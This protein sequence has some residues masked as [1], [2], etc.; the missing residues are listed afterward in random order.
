M[1]ALWNALLH[2]LNTIPAW[3]AAAV[4]GWVAS[5]AITQPAKFLM[6]VGWDSELRA[7]VARALA[8]VSAFVATAFAFRALAPDGALAGMILAAL[9]TGLWSPIAYSLLVAGLRRSDR[10]A[11]IADIL[12]GDVRGGVR[13]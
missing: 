2:V 4:I 12:S 3:L 6:P 13:S 11:W 9:V 8:S 7:V 10:L 5:I 1:S